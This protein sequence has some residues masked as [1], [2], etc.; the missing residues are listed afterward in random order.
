MRERAEA[1]N[2]ALPR[3]SRVRRLA[4]AQKKS[5]PAA[6]FEGARRPVPECHSI[7][8]F[9]PPLYEYRVVAAFFSSPFGS[10]AIFAVMPW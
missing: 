7:G 10:K 9:L 2:N 4:P 6:A 1:G 8:V 5:R 3:I